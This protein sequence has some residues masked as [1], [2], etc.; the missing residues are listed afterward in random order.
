MSAEMALDFTEQLLIFEEFGNI[1]AR[2]EFVQAKE[3]C[4]LPIIYIYMMPYG[5]VG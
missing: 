2:E 5:M 4:G 1:Y 3:V